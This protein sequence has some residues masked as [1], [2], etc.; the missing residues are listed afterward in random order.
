[1]SDTTSNDPAIIATTAPTDM[2]LPVS[3][4]VDGGSKSAKRK[5]IVRRSHQFNLRTKS[6]EKR[7]SDPSAWRIFIVNWK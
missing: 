3:S 2:L 5:I 6:T 7:A 1:M 4:D